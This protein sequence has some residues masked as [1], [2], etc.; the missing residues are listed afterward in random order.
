MKPSRNV[1]QSADSLETA[2]AEGGGPLSLPWQ[3]QSSAV[4]AIKAGALTDGSRFMGAITARPR[5]CVNWCDGRL[6]ARCT[7]AEPHVALAARRVDLDR[8]HH[9]R[10]LIRRQ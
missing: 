3:P 7:R 9:R 10:G 1:F 6:A 2:G 4:H 5:V 8:R